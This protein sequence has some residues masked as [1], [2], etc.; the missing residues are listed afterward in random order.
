MFLTLKFRKNKRN[1]SLWPTIFSKI[2]N[3]RSMV[4]MA[5][6]NFTSFEIPNLKIVVD[7]NPCKIVGTLYLWNAMTFTTKMLA[8]LKEA[9]FTPWKF[10]HNII[11]KP[12]SLFESILCSD[13]WDFKYETFWKIS[14]QVI[15]LQVFKIRNFE[16][17]K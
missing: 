9:N 5:H 15:E 13:K 1:L 14:S 2:L 16:K 4:L 17:L 11:L 12:N 8:G 7:R 6:L 10:L 3:N